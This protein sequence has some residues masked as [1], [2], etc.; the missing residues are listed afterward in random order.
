MASSFKDDDRKWRNFMNA[1]PKVSALEVAIGVQADSVTKREEKVNPVTGRRRIKEG[2][3]SLV[4]I[5]LAN[6]LGTGNIPARPFI[7][8]TSDERRS[9]WWRRFD[10]GNE[11]ALLGGANPNLGFEWVGQLA[12]RDI[13]RK[14]D[15]IKSPANSARTIETKGSSNPLIDTGQM[16]QSITHLVRTAS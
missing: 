7:S 12:T 9:D 13:K 10:M 15:S 16:R 2:G 1:L 6:E 5:A 3:K 8:S 14:I 11:K 4:A